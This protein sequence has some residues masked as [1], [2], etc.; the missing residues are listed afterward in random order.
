MKQYCVNLKLAKELKENGFPQKSHFLWNMSNYGYYFCNKQGYIDYSP[1]EDL[2]APTSDELLKELPNTI[3]NKDNP[4]CKYYL[5]IIKNEI[6]EVS[7]GYE[8]YD[9]WIIPYDYNIENREDKKLSNALAK[10][11]IYLKKEGYLNA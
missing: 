7:Y 5:R 8:D 10:L 4:S 6:F 11:W 2:Y 9:G 3:S 1:Q